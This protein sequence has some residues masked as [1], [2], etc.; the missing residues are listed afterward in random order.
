MEPQISPEMKPTIFTNGLIVSDG[1]RFIGS[2]VVDGW[3]IS[4]IEIGRIDTSTIDRSNFNVIECSGKIIMPGAIDEHVHFRDPGMTEKG[5]IYTESRAAVAG[6]ITS[7]FDMPNTAPPT[8]TIEAWENKMERAAQVSAANYAFFLGATDSNLDQLLSADYTRIPGVKLFLGSS[9]G[10]MLVSDDNSITRLFKNF[11]RVIACHAESEAI[12]AENRRKLSAMHPGGI[13]V[14]YHS[15]IRSSRAC[16]ESTAHAIALAR[17]TGARLHVMHITTADELKL[18]TPG[19]VTGKQITAE[20]CPHYLC[21]TDSSVADT[22]GLTK[23]N[24]AIKTDADRRELL[25]AVADGRIDTIGSDHAPH[26]LRQKQGNAL[27][28]ASGMPSVQFTLPVMMQLAGKGYFTLEDV[29]EKMSSAPAKLFNMTRRGYLRQQY[30]AD[31]VIVNP[32]ADYTVDRK[33]VI[34][35]CGWSPYEG[36]H[37]RY[38]IEQTWVNGQPAYVNGTFTDLH[39][40]LPIRFDA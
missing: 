21:F 15:A 8:T 2:I 33:D 25:R 38:R 23:C 10:G 13:P 20:T 39:T 1:F 4:K 37:L 5:D 3:I 9:T 34:S 16:Y 36:M 19:P 12:I 40:A 32:D 26:L 14:E 35:A 27:T 7:F 24:P 28:A 18:F 11:H 30:A 31:L 6:G 29:V 22:G 17:A